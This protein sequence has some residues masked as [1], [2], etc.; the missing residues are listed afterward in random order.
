MVGRLWVWFWKWMSLGWGPSSTRTVRGCLSYLHNFHVG[1]CLKITPGI[2]HSHLIANTFYMGRHLKITLGL[3]VCPYCNNGLIDMSSRMSIHLRL[4]HPVFS[5]VTSHFFLFSIMHRN[6]SR[7]YCDVFYL[8][9]IEP[10]V[11]TSCQLYDVLLFVT[12]RWI[13]MR[14]KLN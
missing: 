5:F 1:E 3:F 4:V 13:G 8:T 7:L 9:S 10:G 6:K 14:N 11:L 12:Y 2:S